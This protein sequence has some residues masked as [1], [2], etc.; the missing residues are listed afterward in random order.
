[1]V[2][3]RIDKNSQKNGDCQKVLSISTSTKYTQPTGE[4]YERDVPEGPGI[5]PPGDD[6]ALWRFS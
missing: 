3:F 6:N 2:V 4:S 1:M 5:K